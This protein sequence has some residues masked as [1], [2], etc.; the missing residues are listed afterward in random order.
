MG[1]DLLFVAVLAAA[2]LLPTLRNALQL[3]ARGFERTNYWTS[4][5]YAA[6]LTQVE[7]RGEALEARAGALRLRISPV[8]GE[9]EQTRVEVWGKHFAPGLSLALEA[10]LFGRRS[11]KELELGAAGFDARVSIQGSPA[12]ALT[13]LDPGTREAVETML[14]GTGRNTSSARRPK[15]ALPT[16]H[17]DVPLRG[18]CLRDSRPRQLP[19]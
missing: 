3:R 4:A 5:A 16:N 19:A 7:A 9:L 14:E 1:G 11:A 2:F 18:I 6:G 13:L 17:F 10:G 8:H 15:M 12:L